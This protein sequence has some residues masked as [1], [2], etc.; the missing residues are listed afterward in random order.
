MISHELTFY[1]EFHCYGQE[2]NMT[3]I[4]CKKKKRVGNDEINSVSYN[5]FCFLYIAYKAITL[6]NNVGLGPDNL[7][8]PIFHFCFS[9]F[10]LAIALSFVF[11]RNMNA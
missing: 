3:E 2:F 1:Y 4:H 7:F 11:I 6:Q 9:K 10:L 8:S 5:H